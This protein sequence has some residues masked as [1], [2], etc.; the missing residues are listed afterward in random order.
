MIKPSLPYLLL[1]EAHVMCCL[2][3]LIHIIEYMVILLISSQDMVEKRKSEVISHL[4]ASDHNGV[5]STMPLST[6]SVSNGFFFASSILS[7]SD[8]LM[9]I[10]Q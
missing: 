6:E 9:D 2:Y 10:L 1:R 7:I 8:S 3:L 4:Y 5:I